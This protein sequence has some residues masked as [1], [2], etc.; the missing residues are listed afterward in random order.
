MGALI[1]RNVDYVLVD[2]ATGFVT[3][4]FSV[5]GRL[6]DPVVPAGMR[7]VV[8]ADGILPKGERVKIDLRKVRRE[9]VAVESIEAVRLS[10][11]ESQI[12]DEIRFEQRLT[13]AL[14][15][16]D[17]DFAGRIASLAGPLSA[18]HTEKRRQAE[19]GVG[20]LV[21]DE[22][23]RRAILVNAKAQDETIASIDRERRA[24]KARLLF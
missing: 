5:P 19:A 10:W 1:M 16:V 4:L 6:F 13:V 9:I 8:P 23:D 3:G 12:S 15:V 21:A 22:A 7:M 20:P 18:L 2:I 24:I 17:R 11:R 14:G